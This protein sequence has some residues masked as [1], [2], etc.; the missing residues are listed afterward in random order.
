MRTDRFLTLEGGE[1]SGTS[2]HCLHLEKSFVESGR[3][4]VLTREPG[5]TPAGEAIRQLLLDRKEVSDKI[6]PRTATLLYNAARSELYEKVIGPALCAGQIVI[7]DRSSISTNVYQ[8]LV[9]GVPLHEIQRINAFA[10]NWKPGLGIHNP[11]IPDLTIIL[12]I[13]YETGWKRLEES[14]RSLDRIELKG[15]EFHRQVY[16]GYRE[17]YRLY[18]SFGGIRLVDARK[19]I[20]DIHQEI[21]TLLNQRYHL[22]LKPVI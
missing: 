12:D 11:P 19:T 6:N 1:G 2:T 21:V 20:S 15:E 9:G 3:S 13:D 22:D 7:S 14:G 17:Y 8:G 4:V 10:K 18:E 16:E 5:G